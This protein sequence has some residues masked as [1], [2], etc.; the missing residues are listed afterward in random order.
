MLGWAAQDDWFNGEW[1]DAD[2]R[3][4]TKGNSVIYTFSNK[5]K[6]IPGRRFRCSLPQEFKA[7][8]SFRKRQ[9]EIEKIEVFLIQC[10]K[11]LK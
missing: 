6:R 7:Q 4:E 8:A 11:R 3:A 5:R 9:P 2:T 10:G 1:K